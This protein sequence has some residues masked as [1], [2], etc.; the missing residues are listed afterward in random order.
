VENFL[1]AI[2]AKWLGNYWAIVSFFVSIDDFLSEKSLTRYY[3]IA[4]AKYKCRAMIAANYLSWHS[5]FYYS[6]LL[7]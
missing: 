5:A 3:A 1:L 7:C 6:G 2:I 4:K